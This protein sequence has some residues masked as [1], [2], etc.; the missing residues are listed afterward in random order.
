M[1]IT[2]KELISKS[3]FPNTKKQSP[4]PEVFLKEKEFLDNYIEFNTSLI[5]NEKIENKLLIF[6]GIQ[7]Q[8]LIKNLIKA[9]EKIEMNRQSHK[10]NA[11]NRLLNK[12]YIYKSQFLAVMDIIYSNDEL[13]ISHYLIQWLFEVNSIKNE[14]R[15]ILNK[16]DNTLN[17]TKS[18]CILSNFVPDVLNS[19]SNSSNK[20]AS[21]GLKKEYNYLIDVVSSIFLQGNLKDALEFAKLTGI[22]NVYSFL[23]SATPSHNLLL[24]KLDDCL[25]CLDKDLIPF[26]MNEDISQ[27]T[28][29]S[30]IGNGKWDISIE[31]KK[32]HIPKLDNESMQIIQSLLS[33]FNLGPLL[34][35]RRQNDLHLKA[36]FA[37]NSFYISKIITEYR[38]LNIFSESY[39]PQL[40]SYEKSILNEF[41]SLDKVIQYLSIQFFS[42]KSFTDIYFKIEL[43]IIDLFIAPGNDCRKVFLS[44]GNL[45]SSM[46]N[47]I[48]HENTKSYINEYIDK[49]YNDMS[50]LLNKESLTSSIKLLLTKFIF[51]MNVSSYN[52]FSHKLNSILN[53]NAGISENEFTQLYDIHDSILDN[54]LNLL[55]N[56]NISLPKDV[57][58]ICSF[59][60]NQKNLQNTILKL[61]DLYESFPDSEKI[62]VFK[63]FNQEITLKLPCLQENIR[64]FLAEKRKFSYGNDGNNMN[65]SR[66]LLEESLKRTEVDISNE[67]R[68]NFEKIS[69][70]LLNQF[71][72]NNEML[73]I[74]VKILIKYLSLNK[75]IEVEQYLINFDTHID[76]SLI[77]KSFSNIC[78]SYKNQVI[79]YDYSQ[80]LA[81]YNK[82]YKNFKLPEQL[83]DEN[84]HY[85][86]FLLIQTLQSSFFLYSEIQNEILNNPNQVL[87]NTKHNTLVGFFKLSFHLMHLLTNDS[88]FFKFLNFK[89]GEEVLQ[90]L[91]LVFGEWTY[92]LLK[93]SGNLYRLKEKSFVDDENEL[94]FYFYD[95]FVLGDLIEDESN[96][97]VRIN[98]NNKLF[99]YIH[100]E[101]LQAIYHIL[102][103]VSHINPVLINKIY[104][105]DKILDRLKG[106]EDNDFYE[107][108]DY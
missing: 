75:N 7:S 11:L 93:W 5:K 12:N 74:L 63:S 64:L 41:D 29:F 91:S 26:F 84:V 99:P 92:H 50:C 97:V 77:N 43:N 8:I 87:D 79:Y 81:F 96:S 42:Y 10:Q 27:R 71:S 19:H 83:N 30:D 94:N 70:I 60:L 32:R 67:D 54:Y 28:D 62:S 39:I 37:I 35:E 20:E 95:C 89:L 22:F 69:N 86:L 103:E 45:L 25:T 16:P 107:D 88:N 9:N 56:N 40:K 59:Y 90:N 2:L 72:N 44:Y 38:K 31:S 101:K 106:I 18:N 58:F 85:I 34:K 3:T 46:K 80:K 21:S 65:G 33:G 4:T 66:I 6:N 1:D 98:H 52:F 49:T 78:I 68:F 23:K 102:Y 100:K 104:E 73:L 13:I 55:L 51:V 47:L 82:L 36:L 15:I 14:G 105:D 108:Y 76:Y 53:Q 24:S 17:Y 61:S 57:L 48:F